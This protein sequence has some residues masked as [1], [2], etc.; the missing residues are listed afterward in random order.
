MES[1]TGYTFTPWHRHQ[2]E[3]TNGFF[4]YTISKVESQDFTPN[5]MPCSLSGDRTPNGGMLC[6]RANHYTIAPL[7]IKFLVLIN[8]VHGIK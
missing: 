5:N 4:R 3:G 1:T 6:G 2:I 8:A 7:S